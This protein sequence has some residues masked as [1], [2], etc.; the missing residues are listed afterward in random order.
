[1]GHVGEGGNSLYHLNVT[2]LGTS[3]SWALAHEIGH[4]VQWMTGFYRR[5]Y[6]ETT[7]NFW[8]IYVNCNVILN[9]SDISPVLCLRHLF[10]NDKIKIKIPGNISNLLNYK[11]FLSMNTI[12]TNALIIFPKLY[13]C[14]LR[15]E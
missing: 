12:D 11:L 14:L 13:D 9:K 6:K 15:N 3:G 10:Q 4:N 5:D 1:M 2:K 7:N 8:S